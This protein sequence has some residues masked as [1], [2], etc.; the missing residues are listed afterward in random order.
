MGIYHSGRTRYTVVK[1]YVRIAR[2]Q[3]SEVFVPL[4][5]PLGHAQVDYTLPRFGASIRLAM[6]GIEPKSLATKRGHGWI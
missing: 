6:L 1:D 4:A 3:S 5:H 2:T